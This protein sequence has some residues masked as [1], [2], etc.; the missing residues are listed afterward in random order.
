M[1]SKGA[2]VLRVVI[3]AACLAIVA[4]PVLLFKFLGQPF[5]RGFFCND[6]SLMHPLKT[7]TIP[8]VIVGIIGIGFTSL[9]VVAVE[10]IRC[11][12]LCRQKKND[13]YVRPEDSNGKPFLKTLVV[14][15]YNILVPFYFGGVMTQL[16]TDIGKFSVGRLRPHFFDACKPDFSKINCSLGYIEDYTCLQTDEEIVRNAKLSFPSGHSSLSI[17]TM[18]YFSM[19][20]Q[21]A[22]PRLPS[23]LIR[24]L[25]QL[26]L[27][28]MAYYTCLSRISDYKHHW[29]DVLGGGILGLI[30]S[31]VVVFFMSEMFKRPKAIAEGLPLK[32]SSGDGDRNVA[33]PTQSSVIDMDAE[34]KK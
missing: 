26:A 13:D 25:L 15:C 6:Q 16:F 18:V 17:Y 7:S 19:Y 9:V 33:T 31:F 3:D 22:M 12:Q 29:S 5:K 32:V 23:R 30:T 21:I 10:G 1:A 24:P 34:Y 11:K 4:I 8:T 28:L 14:R 2:V 20:I 27:I